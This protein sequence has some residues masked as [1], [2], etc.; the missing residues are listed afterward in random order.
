VSAV[1]SVVQHAVQY[2]SLLGA[3][4]MRLLVTER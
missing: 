4:V 3:D 1:A 2:T